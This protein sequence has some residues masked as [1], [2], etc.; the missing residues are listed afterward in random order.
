MINIMAAIFMVLVAAFLLYAATRPG[1]FRVQRSIDIKAPPEKIFGLIND[2]HDFVSW[3]PYEKLDPAMKKTYSGAASGTGA[4]YAWEGNSKAG[5]GRM[6]ITQSSPPS[7][8][9]ANLDFLKP[10]KAHNIV[11][12][13]LQP[14]GGSTNVTWA[15]HGPLS[16]MAKVM[17]MVFNMDRMVGKDFETGLASLKTLAEA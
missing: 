4:V 12:F 14:A 16:Y 7:K 5:V 10:F 11:E 15:M 6:E 3:S 13:T 1:I 2:F 8:V 9:T 17:H